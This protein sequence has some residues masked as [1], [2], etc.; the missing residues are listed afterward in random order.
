MRP[1]HTTHEEDKLIEA[2]ERYCEETSSEHIPPLIEIIRR[3]DGMIT[4][5]DNYSNTVEENLRSEARDHRSR[6][7]KLEAENR[8]LSEKLD[9]L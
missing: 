5:N 6:I 8:I 4:Q 1:D 7:E 3:L 9:E 2:A